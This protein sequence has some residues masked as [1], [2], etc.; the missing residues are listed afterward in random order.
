MVEYLC[1]VEPLPGSFI[2]VGNNRSEWGTF[3]E[4]PERVS[5]NV[6]HDQFINGGDVS[7]RSSIPEVNEMRY[8]GFPRGIRVDITITVSDAVFHCRTDPDI[9]RGGIEWR[10]LD[11]ENNAVN[12]EDRSWFQDDGRSMLLREITDYEIGKVVE[13]RVYSESSLSTVDSVGFTVIRSEDT[14]STAENEI[15]N[16]SQN[17]N[18]CAILFGIFFTL[19]VLS[20]LLLV[21]FIK[22]EYMYYKNRES[23]SNSLQI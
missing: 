14:R 10:L 5:E 21:W 1:E 9:S 15:N 3:S 23:S 12:I 11:D 7:C 18:V 6:D 2:N 17:G 8:C 13:C 4:S 20:L 19:F 16:S 22:A